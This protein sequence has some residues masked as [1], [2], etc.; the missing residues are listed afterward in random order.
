[1]L[2]SAGRL[3]QP[4]DQMAIY[5]L[6]AEAEVTNMATGVTLH[7]I[8][9]QALVRLQYAFLT[10]RCYQISHPKQRFKHLGWTY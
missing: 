6:L 3:V 9:E 1:M 10:T 2:L 4:A 8:N 7:V 5:F